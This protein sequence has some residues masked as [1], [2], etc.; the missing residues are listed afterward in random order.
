MDDQL[1]DER[2]PPVIAMASSAGGIAALQAVV[3]ALP[4]DLPAAVLIVQHL[5]PDHRSVL[6][7]ILARKSALQIRQAQQ[8]ERIMAG[9]AYIAPPDQHLLL[10]PDGDLLLTHTELVHFVRPSADLLFESV[11]AAAGGRAMAVVLSGSGSDGAMGCT[12]MKARGAR[13][14]AQDKATAE[15]FGMPG[16]AFETG[17]VD[18]VLPL[19]EIAGAIIAFA[20]GCL[21]WQ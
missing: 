21:A 5:D 15:Y 20:R 16:A 18:D 4:A 1:R 19:D 6:A 17:C 7:E 14:V 9:T 2:M 13:V 12:A 3:A 10:N 8:G 11:A